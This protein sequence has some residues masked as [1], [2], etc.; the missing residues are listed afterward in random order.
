MISVLRLCQI[1]LVF[2]FSLSAFASLQDDTTDATVVDEISDD[3]PVT[4]EEI[5]GDRNLTGSRPWRE[6]NYS[7]QKTAMGWEE[8]TFTVP[9]GL[10]TNVKF[11][12]DVYTKWSSDQG[13]LHDSEQI[14]LIYETLDFSH[15]SSRTDLDNYQKDRLKQ[16]MVKVAKRRI[17]DMLKRLQKIK[18]PAQL[19]SE[20]KRIWTAFEKFEGK[21]KFIEACKKSRLR[22]QL[23]QRDRIVQGIFF[24]GRYLEEFEKIFKEQGLPMELTRLAF[25]ESSF[26]VLARSKVGASGIWQ[27][28]PYT[29]RPYMMMNSAIDKRNHPIEATKLAAKLLKFNF[30]TLRSWPLAITGYNHGPHGVLRLTKLFKTRDISEMVQKTSSRRR[31]GFASRNFYA[32]FLA[33]LEAEKNAPMYFGSVIWSKPIESANIKLE[34]PIKYSDLLKW[35]DGDDKKAQIFNPHITASARK[36]ARPLPKGAIISVPLS[37]QQEVLADL[38]E[39]KKGKHPRQAAQSGAE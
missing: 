31:L 36:N 27:I 7:D 8:T 9:K 14:D 38:S 5:A 32:S 39:M 33:I 29:A 16:K 2:I 28:M 34:T 3:T 24:S 26:N 25:V 21:N 35:F 13:V 37:K 10:E 12:L 11:W 20:E 6:P 15:I 4:H 23:G 30:N 1:V 18:D 19:D 17:A 22:F